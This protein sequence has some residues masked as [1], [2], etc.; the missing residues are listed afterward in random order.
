M[1]CNALGRNPR[2]GGALNG[3][4]PPPLRSLCRTPRTPAARNGGRAQEARLRPL[5]RGA[6][7]WRP[8]RPPPRH[9]SPVQGDNVTA[10]LVPRARCVELLVSH[11]RQA[12][13]TYRRLGS[14][15]EA[16][17][18]MDPRL[19]REAEGAWDFTAALHD[20]FLRYDY[21]AL[22]AAVL[23]GGALDQVLAR[24]LRANSRAAH[25][26]RSSPGSI[27]RAWADYIVGYPHYVRGALTAHDELVAALDREASRESNPPSPEV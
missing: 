20:S 22:P 6:L 7:A 11:L 16:A 27:G 15:A 13:D 18:G 1:G 26:I 2:W 12:Q 21:P 19:L 4:P 14:C 5:R 24:S 17:P 23:A 10:T 25:H 3:A 8:S 9:G